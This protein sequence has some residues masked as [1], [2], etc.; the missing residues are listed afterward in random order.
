MLKRIKGYFLSAVDISL[1]YKMRAWLFSVICGSMPVIIRL[2]I[3]SG[4]QE[5]DVSYFAL[6][7]AAFWGIMMN[8]AAF[9]NISSHKDAG[10]ELHSLVVPIIF[11]LTFPLMVIYAISALLQSYSVTLWITTCVLLI[12]S[13]LF[14]YASACDD[15]VRDIQKTLKLAD[16]LVD[17]EP[18]FREHM[19]RLYKEII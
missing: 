1:N 9:A 16:D 8:T 6:T 12:V 14:S 18:A 13:F 7:D 11:L 5:Q 3:A 2:L 4:T 10:R 17:G 15:V 19:T